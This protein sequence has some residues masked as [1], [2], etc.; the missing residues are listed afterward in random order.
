MLDSRLKIIK[1]LLFCWKHIQNSFYQINLRINTF[2]LSFKHFKIVFKIQITVSILKLNFPI[3]Q[4]IVK[5]KKKKKKKK[6]M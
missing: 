2:L 3:I 1:W 6:S 5:K 4:R